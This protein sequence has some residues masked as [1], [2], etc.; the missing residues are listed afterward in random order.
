M[1]QDT[2]K[3]QLE[4]QLTGVQRFAV[5]VVSLL[6]AAS[7]LLLGIQ[8]FRITDPYVLNVLSLS[9]SPAQGRL[10]FQMNCATCHG[11]EASGEVGP[12][13]Q[14]ISERKSRVGLIEQVTGGKTPPMPQFQPEAKV[15]AD[16]LS[17]LETL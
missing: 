10:I 12:S 6:A 2:Y 15:M 4:P 13:L 7:L 16:L 9:G 14:D 8:H 17:Y 11:L 3:E 1:T 5:L